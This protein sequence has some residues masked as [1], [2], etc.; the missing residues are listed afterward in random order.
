MHE[1][2]PQRHDS[3]RLAGAT[4][5]SEA[6][7]DDRSEAG[8]DDRSEAGTDDCPA[9]K[10]DDR[11]VAAADDCSAAQPVDRFAADADAGFEIGPDFERFAQRNDIYRRSFHDPAIRSEKTI[12]F[13]RT[14]RETLSQWRKADGFTQRDYALRNAAWHVSDLFTE[15]RVA[16]DRREGFSDPY[17]QQLPPAPERASFDSPEAAADEIRRVGRLFGA[18]AL[19][20]APRD[21]R[22]IYA[23]KTSDMS[24]EDRPVDLPAHLGHVIVV[25]MPM[26]RD[27]I[28]TV[29]SA[30]SGAATG[31]GYSQDTTTLLALTQYIR[32]LGYDAV[33][34]ANDSALA[35]PIA[36]QAGLGEYGR[37]GLVITRDFGPRVRLGKIFTDLPLAADRPQRFGV[38]EFCGICRAC[39]D[40]CPVGAIPDSPP[41]PPPPGPSYLRGVRKWTIDAEK[42]FGYWAQQNTDCAICV[43][44]CPYNRDYT[45]W[46]ARAWRWLAGTRARRIALWIDRVSGR[47]RRMPPSKWWSGGRR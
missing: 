17:T 47:G 43:R 35:V 34:S 21:D 40:G 29:P 44:V 37:L 1:P 39:S 22:W 6:G 27:L 4:D 38:R 9:A 30:L 20:I 10:G 5:R 32:N 42:C 46:H 41:G 15:A 24:G 16:D 12:R 11:F 26:D 8:A 19:G 45:R 3:R 23:S 28:S 25:A 18:G 36:I 14:Y 2:D 33:A 7:T 31:W 13:Y